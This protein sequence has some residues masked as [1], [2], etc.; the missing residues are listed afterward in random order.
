MKPFNT[1]L[2]ANRG[3]I[4][5]RII[6]TAKQMG[7]QTIAVYS[8][9]DANSL[10]VK[11]ADKAVYI[12]TDEDQPYL[13]IDALLLAAERAKAGAIH[14]GYGFLSESAE[15]SKRCEQVGITFVGPNEM[16]I[17]VMGNKTVAR[18]AMAKAFV[19]LVPGYE[20]AS[21]DDVVLQKEAKRIGYPVMVKAAAG[22]GGRGIR[23]VNAAEN[24]VNEAAL[25]RAEALSSFGSDELLLEK[26]VEQ[27]RH[28]EIQ[29]FAD[30]MGNTVYLGERDCSM[31]RRHQK[32]IEESPAPMMSEKL[33][34]AM[35]EAAV[36]AAKAVDYVGAGTIEFLV[37]ESGDFYFLEMN[38]RLQVE[39]PVTELV[40]GLDLVEWQLR[41]AAGEAL[42]L[43]QDDITLTGHAI[44]VRL[45]AEDCEQ[46][47]VPQTGDIL[48]WTMPTGRG[49]RVD[50]GI[51][52]GQQVSPFYDS[53]LAKIITYGDSRDE[54]LR[55]LKRALKEC[56]LLGLITNKQFLLTLLE[57]PI[58]VEGH[59]TTRH[60][61]DNILSIDGSP[62]EKPLNN[63]DW[64]IAAVLL[65]RT[66]GASGWRSTGRLRWPVRLKSNECIRDVYVS[67]DGDSF[68]IE[69]D[70]NELVRL[71]ILN[72]NENENELVVLLDDVRQTINTAFDNSKATL[73]LDTQDQTLAFE[74]LS[75]SEKKASEHTGSDLSAPMSGRIAEVKITVGQ[76]ITK[77][78]VLVV[79][80]SMKMFQE[81]SATADGVVKDIFVKEDIQVNI[82]DML[83][84]ID[85]KN[86]ETDK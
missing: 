72:E 80:E 8:H 14:P 41:V 82:G 9:A 77:G 61:E 53:M 33:R 59:A 75:F 17:A 60:I 49:V 66:V 1:L 3:E 86:K 11:Q 23:L 81:L 7:Y 36:K 52:Q 58:F 69:F 21:N 20:G 76:T 42:P 24:L 22:G 73:Y 51:A 83:V 34:K 13:N 6:K 5:V 25:A 56:V 28:I 39:H 27:A 44:E 85:V 32:V 46:G 68:Q 31:Q 43:T 70:N 2:I 79:L 55:R 18:E 12:G 37:T 64:A 57:D 84:E 47:F 30:E 38:T 67:Q 35:G 78:D 40:T 45:Y 62:E 65:S 71:L 54:A 63:G 16:A 4:A 48:A 26:C 29:I 10:H 74:K 50:A 15:F 19:P